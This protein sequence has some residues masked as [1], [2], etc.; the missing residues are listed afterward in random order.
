MRSIWQ[1]LCLLASLL[2]L[3]FSTATV[4]VAQPSVKVVAS[5][6]ILADLVK[7]IGGPQ[8]AVETLVQPGQDPHVFQPRPSDVSKLRD[9]DLIVINGAG[10]DSWMYRLIAA[11]EFSANMARVTDGLSLA[12]ATE[13]HRHSR[14]SLDAARTADGGTAEL[15]ESAA[16]Q[17]KLQQVS[18]TTSGTAAISTVVDEAPRG[19]EQEEAEH[20]EHESGDDPHVWQDPLNVV[21]IVHV[22]AQALA[23]VDPEHARDY[24]RRAQSY[25]LRLHELHTKI[26]REISRIPREHR[27]VI[28]NHAAM[29]YYGARYGIDFI[30]AQGASTATEPSA[31]ELAQLVREARTGGISAVF[32]EGMGNANVLHQVARE[33]GLSVGGRL[34]TD[35]L[36]PPE[37]PAATYLDMMEHNTE[38]LV[39]ALRK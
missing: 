1:K 26:E 32:I 20:A 18:S 28:T 8:V 4:G 10:F 29:A 9:A 3:G 31:R 14:G 2:M 35:S 15:A 23:D 24:Q 7:Q 16:P 21:H 34:F 37:G 22:I 39:K 5:F 11:A 12:T 27:R 25:A 36:S 33:A 30:A 38:Q 13:A 17:E 6:T 19:P